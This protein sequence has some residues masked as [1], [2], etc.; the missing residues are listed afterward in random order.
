MLRFCGSA[1][2]S[3]GELLAHRGLDDV[4]GLTISSGEMLA[5]TRTGKNAGIG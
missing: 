3:D 5:D 2:T 4:L 1:I